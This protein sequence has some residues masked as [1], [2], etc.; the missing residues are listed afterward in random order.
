MR[1][2]LRRREFIAGLGGAAVFPLG[3]RAQQAAMPVIGHIGAYPPGNERTLAAI[4]KG[5][6]ET[7]Y[8]EGRN[9]RI[10][11]RWVQDRNDR[12]PALLRD[13]IERRVAVLATTVSTAAALAAKAATQTIPIVFRIGGDPVAAGLV[14]RLNQPGGNVTGTTTLGVELGP[15]R[16]QMLREMLPT[17]A[18][19]TLFS[20]PRNANAAAETREIQAAANMLDIRLLVLNASSP[21]ELDVV[22]ER[23][24]QQDIGGILNAADPFIISRRTGR[25]PHNPGYLFEPAVLGSRRPHVLWH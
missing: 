16:L 23:I 1:I 9:L 15:K 11:Y 25:T 21:S 5:L 22:F 20:N 24:A 17:R 10:E 19:V 7:G 4:R 13:L 3:A 8:V 14:T 12:L 6:M 2:C 18:T